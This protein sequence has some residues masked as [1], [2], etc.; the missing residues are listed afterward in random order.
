MS[1]DVVCSF[2]TFY[3]RIKKLAEEPRK[4]GGKVNTGSPALS[5]D[6]DSL[7]SN[8][9]AEIFSGERAST[10]GGENPVQVRFAKI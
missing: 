4:F 3:S 10:L 1:F 9:E 8:V 5:V 2:E 6:Y 7:P